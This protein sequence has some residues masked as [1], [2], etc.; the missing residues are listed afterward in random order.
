MSHTGVVYI[1]NKYDMETKTA[2]ENMD[3]KRINIRKSFEVEH[4]A[5]KLRV[6]PEQLKNAVKAVGISSI[7]VALY[8]DYMLFG[9]MKRI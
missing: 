2:I 3:L 5:K 9:K 7:N 6:T 4:W 8:L 1:L